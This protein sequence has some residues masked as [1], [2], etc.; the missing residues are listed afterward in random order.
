MKTITKTLMAAGVAVAMT[1]SVASAWE[2]PTIGA[3]VGV[4]DLNFS[5]PSPT[6]NFNVVG[7]HG[8]WMFRVRDTAFV[9]GPEV[10]LTS[11][12]NSSVGDYMVDVN[13]IAGYEFGDWTPYIVGGYT[14]VEGSGGGENGY[15]YGVGV[16]YSINDNVSLGL[17]YTYR[18]TDT[19]NTEVPTTAVTV[20]YSF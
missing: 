10:S 4:G 12:S 11:L 1:A 2:G 15:N 16:A 20:A 5:T 14:R 6:D 19:S 17:R 18:K 8:N 9:F 7:I 3:H 13:G